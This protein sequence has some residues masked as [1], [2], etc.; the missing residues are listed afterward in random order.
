MCIQLSLIIFII[1]KL[2][3]EFAVETCVFLKILIKNQ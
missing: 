1:D 2:M 3:M